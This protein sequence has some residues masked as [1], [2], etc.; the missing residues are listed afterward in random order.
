MQIANTLQGSQLFSEEPDPPQSVAFARVFL[1]IKSI[2]KNLS[3]KSEGKIK[4]KGRL[5]HV[6]AKNIFRIQSI[7]PLL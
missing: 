7:A 1:E 2:K 3:L 5:C 4:R 6:P